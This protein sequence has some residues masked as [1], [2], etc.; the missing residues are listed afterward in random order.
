MQI[1]SNLIMS[2]DSRYNEWNSRGV[3][4]LFKGNPDCIIPV[5]SVDE[6]KEALL[7]A[8]RR[9]LHVVVRGGGHCLE[10]FV[11]NPD[12]QVIIDVSKMKG[13]R[14]DDD[15]NCFEVMGGETVGQMLKKLYEGWGVVLPVGEHPDIGIG[16]HIPGGAFGWLCRQ[17]GLAV[18]YLYAVELLW[19][20]E[21][22]DVQTV[23][24]T[25]LDDDPNREL[26]WAHTGG[27]AGNFGIALRYWF[28]SP[29]S[30]SNEPSM[31][32]PKAPPAVETF[33]IDWQWDNIN[34]PAFKKLV[35]N[36]CEWCAN[37]A[38]PETPANGVFCT[39][40]LWH[41]LAGKI[42]LKGVVT[43]PEK[44]ELLI[45]DIIQNLKKGVHLTYSIK[46]TKMSWMDFALHPFPDIF[47]EGKGAFKLKDAFLLK[48]FTG[49]QLK[50]IYDHLIS[51]DT[52]GSFIGMA[53]YGGMVN[54][55][56]P[57]A[58]ASIQRNAIMTMVCVSGWA[59]ANEKD[60]YLETLPAIYHDL[61]A[62]TGGLPIPNEMTG[63][64]IIAHPDT[65]LIDPKMNPSGVPWHHMYY[66]TNYPR[67][68]KVKARWDPFNIFHHALSVSA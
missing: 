19:V 61:F 25:K 49:D 36:F 7:Y 63:G 35:G 54:T 31:V 10:G 43:N 24:A 45:G 4:E 23:I 66:Q 18:D 38:S 53:T 28:R 51:G 12:V 9:D 1:P 34:E 33:E 14:F 2:I 16:G 55:I 41:K 21:N 27:G 5:A 6:L 60:K 8:I 58:T 20:N 37:N 3:N 50:I 44:A 59:D 65:D 11:A 30:V 47:P 57:D 26:W 64:C 32:L 22:K 48:P 46:R 42:Q 13:V 17:L 62:G 56:A 67:L 40:H 68:Q 52:P 15:F 29:G 39:M